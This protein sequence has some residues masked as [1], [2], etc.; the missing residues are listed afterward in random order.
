MA[1]GF[2]NYQNPTSGVRAPASAPPARTPASAA[3][4]PAPASPAIGAGP[5]LDP[6]VTSSAGAFI[7]D[8]LNYWGM[9][10]LADWYWQGI[11]DGKSEPEL[12]LELRQKPEY[13]TRFPA[14]ATL[15]AQGAGMDEAHYI[16]YEQ[17][18]RDSLHYYGVPTGIYDTPDA[19]AKL[20]IA[21]VAPPEVNERLRIAASAVYQAP[22]EVRQSLQDNYAIGAGDLIAYFLD[23]D[24]MTPKLQAQYASAQ[25]QGASRI[26]GVGTSIATAERL[27]AQGITLGD[28]L[29]GFGT[30]RQT[31]AYLAGYGETVNRAQLE[32]SAFGEAAAADAVS[33]VKRSRLSGFQGGGAPLESAQGVTGLRSAATT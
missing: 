4:A 11:K 17:T 14:M 6:A 16:G 8:F 29:K 26:Q 25:V 10:G 31:Q 1:Y 19:I 5:S 20:M 23:P 33:R 7:R 9:S 3:P 28:A 32:G 2:P 27:A 12:Y 18:V 22:V 15:D 30:V 13:K 24:V 21:G